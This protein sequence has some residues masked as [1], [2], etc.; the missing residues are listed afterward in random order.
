MFF[1]RCADAARWARTQIRSTGLRHVV[2]PCRKY[3]CPPKE[4]FGQDWIPGFTV[5]LYEEDAD[6]NL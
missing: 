3:L 1:R 5:V 6:Y 2:R 4:Y